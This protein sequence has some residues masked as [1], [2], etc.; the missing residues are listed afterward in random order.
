MLQSEW[1]QSSRE[2][3]QSWYRIDG[4]EHEHSHACCRLGNLDFFGAH[5]YQ[6][7]RRSRLSDVSWLDRSSGNRLTI[8]RSRRS[9][10]PTKSG[11]FG[12]H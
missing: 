8:T 12:C 7:F 9:G 3:L 4:C 1:Y 10:S 6:S 5:A 11:K 2:G